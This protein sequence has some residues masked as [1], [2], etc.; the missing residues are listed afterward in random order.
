MSAPLDLVALAREAP[1]EQLPGLIYSLLQAQAVAFARMISDRRFGSSDGR[2]KAAALA[3]PGDVK[4]LSAEEAA[5]RLGVSV[6]YLYKAKHLPFR[7]RIGR[8]VVF[9][10]AGLERWNRQRQERG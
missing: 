7:T 10:A 9:D 5:R 3:A 1:A 6:D 2:P 4:N 8:R